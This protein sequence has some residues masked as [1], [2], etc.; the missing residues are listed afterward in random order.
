MPA[1]PRQPA[2]LPSETLPGRDQAVLV[3]GPAS[4]RHEPD[5]VAP[6]VAAL[7]VAV[8]ADRQPRNTI[9]L[10]LSHLSDPLPGG[11]D[12]APLF[13]LSPAGGG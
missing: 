3:M 6:A 2:V 7:A 9:V 4:V 8:P 11:R 5:A 12:R 10:D 13:V 1:Q